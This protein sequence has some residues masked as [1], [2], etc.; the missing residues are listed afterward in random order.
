[1]RAWD[2]DGPDDPGL[3]LTLTAP[4]ALTQEL[5]VTVGLE[6]AATTSRA[7]K[8][9]PTLGPRV[10][11]VD[12]AIRRPDG[13]EFLFEPLLV[14]CRRDEMI[15][16]RAGDPPVRD[17]AFIHYGKHGFAFGRPGRY[18]VRA[19]YAPPEGPVVLSNI[20]AIQVR[21][22]V[23]GVDRRVAELIAG[24]EQVG[25]L[26]SLAGSD[27]RALQ[28]GAGRLKQIMDRHPRHPVAGVARLIHGTN[29][30]RGFKWV[31]GDGVVR[32]RGPR[33]EEA[34]ALVSDVVDLDRPRGRLGLRAD[35][36]PCLGGFFNSRRLEV[37]T[38][39]L[40]VVAHPQRRAGK[41]RP[42]PLDPV[43]S[44]IYSRARP[45]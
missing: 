25:T 4:S 41:D 43:Q 16:L 40:P 12:I 37:T 27:S 13:S 2:V 7:R 32:L 33:L 18:L 28:R 11:T 19:R 44:P 6:L 8:V 31:D 35:V 5:P 45:N 34:M 1:V 23:S 3:R 24:D 9:P 36:D 15:E 21:E 17:H 42:R 26:M 14:H 38:A 20:A 22:S 10:S 29:L 39:V 30:A